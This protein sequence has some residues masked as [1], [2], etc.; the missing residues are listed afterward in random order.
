MGGGGGGGKGSGENARE[1]VDGGDRNL[2]GCDTGVGPS[3]V[4]DATRTAA[5]DR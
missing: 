1:D 3:T 5:G 2:R 4:R